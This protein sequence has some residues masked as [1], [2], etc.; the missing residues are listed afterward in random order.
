MAEEREPI[1][2][3][4]VHRRLNA[5]RLAVEQINKLSPDRRARVLRARARLLATEEEKTPEQARITVVEFLLAYEHYAI[6]ST[7]IR[8]IYYMR[9][10]TPLPGTPAFILGIINIRGEICSI[11]DLK[12]IFG[13]PDQGLPEFNKVIV[14]QNPKMKFGIVTDAII[15]TRTINRSSIRPPPVSLSGILG[16]YLVGVTDEPLIIVDAERLLTDKRMIVNEHV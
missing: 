12:K 1:Q 14:V 13:L 5:A 15:G 11:V 9:D 2:W 7:H 10:L 6:E 8:E 4:D 16:E 3:E